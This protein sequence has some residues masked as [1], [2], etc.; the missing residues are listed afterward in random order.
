MKVPSLFKCCTAE[1]NEGSTKITV[2]SRCFDRPI[3]FNVTNDIDPEQLIN[4][5]VRRMTKPKEAVAPV[6]EASTPT[7]QAI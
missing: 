3:I 4:D 1:H 7:E 6:D 2:K 5:I